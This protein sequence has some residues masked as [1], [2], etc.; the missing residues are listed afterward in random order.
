MLGCG[1]GREVDKKE[2]T[3]KFPNATKIVQ[4][5]TDGNWVVCRYGVGAGVGLGAGARVGG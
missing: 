5:W 2:D 4:R 1:D 3:N